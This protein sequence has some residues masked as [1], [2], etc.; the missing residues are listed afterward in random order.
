MP[1]MPNTEYSGHKSPR[2]TLS[3]VLGTKYD[4]FEFTAETI[5]TAVDILAASQNGVSTYISS[6]PKIPL[7]SSWSL[8]ICGQ[9]FSP[10][11]DDSK[12]KLLVWQRP[13]QRSN[14]E[15]T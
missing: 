13:R 3:S 4:K 14:S 1:H 7:T 5:N 11:L 2:Q 12:S 9:E 6:T 15:H 10:L 8:V